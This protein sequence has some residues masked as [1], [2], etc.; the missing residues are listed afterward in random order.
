MMEK[1]VVPLVKEV[2]DFWEQLATDV[3]FF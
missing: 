2:L 1:A 3:R